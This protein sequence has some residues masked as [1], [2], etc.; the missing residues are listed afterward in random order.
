MNGNYLAPG[1]GNAKFTDQRKRTRNQSPRQ[2]DQQTFVH[3]T[4][5]FEISFLLLQMP[6]NE[7]QI[8]SKSAIFLKRGNRSALFARG[9]EQLLQGYPGVNLL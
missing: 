3:L 9:M 7:Q 6:Q 1:L 4:S 5:L 2:E 8:V